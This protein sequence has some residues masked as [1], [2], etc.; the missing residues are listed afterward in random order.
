MIYSMILII[1]IGMILNMSAKVLM[2]QPFQ[3]LYH[4]QLRMSYQSAAY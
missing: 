2:S 3:M 4:M 1:K